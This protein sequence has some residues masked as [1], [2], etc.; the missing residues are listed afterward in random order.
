MKARCALSVLCNYYST[1]ADG[2]GLKM[3]AHYS[4]VLSTNIKCRIS[5][6]AKRFNITALYRSILILKTFWLCCGGAFQGTI[7]GSK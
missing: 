5:P 7:S 4:L 1:L 6:R 2:Y 3:Q